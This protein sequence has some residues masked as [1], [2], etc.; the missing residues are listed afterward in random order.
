[1]TCKF[2]IFFKNYVIVRINISDAN[3]FYELNISNVL[4]KEEKHI[5]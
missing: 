5:N 2:N 1:M 4:L 3:I